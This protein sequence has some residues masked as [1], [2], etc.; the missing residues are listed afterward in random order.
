M[1]SV[2]SF[3]EILTFVGNISVSLAFLIASRAPI[4]RLWAIFCVA[5]SLLGLG[6]FMAIQA[7]QPGDALFWWQATHFLAIAIPALYLYFILS[8]LHHQSPVLLYA[9]ASASAV[10]LVWHLVSDM[11]IAEVHVMFGGVYYFTATPFYR[12]F[13]VFLL[14]CMLCGLAL[15]LHAR[16]HASTHTKRRKT[17]WVLIATI[18]GFMAGGM[19][20]LP[21]YGIAIYP[22]FIH[23]VALAPLLAG[24]RIYSHQIQHF[25]L[26]T[27]GLQL[28]V[29]VFWIFILLRSFFMQYQST[30]N[31][32]NI[33]LLILSG[34][35]SIYLVRTMMQVQESREHS[36]RLARYLANANARLRELD[37]QKTEF[38]S[39]ASH[40]LRNPIAAINGYSTMMVE[41]SFGVLPETFKQPLNRIV[42]S[43]KR[44]AFMVDD[45]LNVSRMEQGKMSYN[46]QDIDLVSLIRKAAEEPRVIAEQKGLTYTVTVPKAPIH[47]MGDAG[48]LKQVFL[49]LIDNAIKYTSQGWVRVRVELSKEKKVVLISIQDSGIGVAPEEQD[50]LFQK[51]NRASNANTATVYGSGLGLYI[52][53]EILKAHKGWVH[54]HSEGV[55]KGTT[56]TI[57]LPI[58]SKQATDRV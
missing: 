8:F 33:I 2:L 38:V 36:E 19:V 51:F 18:V 44:I 14:A 54:I 56:F 35:I 27:I 4:Q 31:Y 9:I 3:F 50:A 21:A 42:E 10:L 22:Y 40:Q 12:I 47:V 57:E 32:L 52:A 6:V 13:L 16:Q 5:A 48:K 1:Y 29:V 15:L 58:M 46:E 23:L 37:R 28:F 39:M 43:G 26:Q 24:Y 53:R 7:Q 49:N 25:Q 34:V 20:F 45:F 17:T 11:L 41:Q 55:G 30:G